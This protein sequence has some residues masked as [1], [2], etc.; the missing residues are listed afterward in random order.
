VRHNTFNLGSKKGAQGLNSSKPFNDAET[1]LVGY[2][3]AE[4]QAAFKKGDLNAKKEYEETRDKWWHKFGHSR[5]GL[6]HVASIDEDRQRQANVRA[7]V[8]AVG[9]SETATDLTTVWKKM[10]NLLQTMMSVHFWMTKVP[11]EVVK[12]NGLIEKMIRKHILER[13]GILCN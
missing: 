6:E 1:R 8:K 11:T 2:S 12:A 9:P 7:A 13:M 3:L 4:R 5:R 10:K